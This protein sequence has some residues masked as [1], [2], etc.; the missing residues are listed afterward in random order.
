MIKIDNPVQIN[1]VTSFYSLRS[2]AQ[3][4]TTNNYYYGTDTYNSSNYSGEVNTQG[5]SLANTGNAVLVVIIIGSILIFSAFVIK[6]FG[7]RKFSSHS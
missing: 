2:F 3:A 5:A 7:R 6:I 4:E 1:T